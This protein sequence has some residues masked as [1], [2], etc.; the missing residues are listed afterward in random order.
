M[1]I[2]SNAFVGHCE[3]LR[4]SLEEV[5]DSWQESSLAGGRSLPLRSTPTAKAFLSPGKKMDFSRRSRYG[6]TLEA[7]RLVDTEELLTWYLAAFPAKTSAS[8][9]VAKAWPVSTADY[10]GIWLGSFAKANLNSFGWRTRR[11]SLLGGLMPF[12]GSWPQWGLMR[13]G[14]CLALRQREPITNGRGSLSWATPT[15]ND[16]QNATL[17]ESQ[18]HRNSGIPSQLLQRFD[19]KTGRLPVQLYASLMGW[20]S[21]W[22]RLQPMEMGKFH[23]WLSLHG[24]LSLSNRN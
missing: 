12:S 21:T 7:L 13:C 24:P 19:I 15:R 23:E 1:W 9:G 10:G 22:T 14:E 5:E 18:R 17:P 20:P 8:Q 11:Y 4:F 6:M 3:R 16:S 2:L